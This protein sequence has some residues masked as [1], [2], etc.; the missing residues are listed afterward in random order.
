MTMREFDNNNRPMISD[1]DGPNTI[2]DRRSGMGW[3][4]ALVVLAIVL[5]LGLF[6]WTSMDNSSRVATNTTPGVTTGASPASP[7]A[8]APA[9]PNTGP[10]NTR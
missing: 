6:A 5:G 9:T 3:L 4:G 2:D 10:T 8:P 7:P 1:T